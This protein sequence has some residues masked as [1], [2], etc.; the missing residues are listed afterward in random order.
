MSFTQRISEP[1][2]KRKQFQQIY[3]KATPVDKYLYKFKEKM[4]FDLQLMRNDLHMDQNFILR[5][6]KQKPK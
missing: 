6:N 4:P 3:Q 2:K 5:K 1:W